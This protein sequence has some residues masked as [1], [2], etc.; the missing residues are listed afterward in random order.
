MM[1]SAKSGATTTMGGRVRVS[2]A[3]C[4]EKENMA[5]TELREAAEGE[6]E[7]QGKR[8]GVLQTD[9]HGKEE[10]EQLS[11]RALRRGRV[12]SYKEPS[13]MS[14][15]RRCLTD[16]LTACLRNPQCFCVSM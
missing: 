10:K 7:K 9:V 8:E 4:A 6:N 16:C 13:I 5:V 12:L 1:H 14:K 11:R 2:L 3:R 15:I